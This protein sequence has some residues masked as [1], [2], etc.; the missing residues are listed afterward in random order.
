MNDLDYPFYRQ[1]GFF[2]PIGVM[3]AF[4]CSSFAGIVLGA[5]YGSLTPLVPYVYLNFTGTLGVGMGAGAAVYLGA[6]FGKIR[7][8]M[9]CGLI[10]S[11]AGVAALWG[12]WVAWIYALSSVDQAGVIIL[13]PAAI[14]NLMAVIGQEGV[15][16][17]GKSGSIPVRGATLYFVWVIEAGMIITIATFA[18]YVMMRGKPFCERCSCWVKHK[19]KLSELRPPKDYEV[20]DRLIAGD[21]S[22]VLTLE[23]PLFKGTHIQIE[24]LTC[25]T[26]D[27][28]CL[29]NIALVVASR[30]ED[31]KHQTHTEQ[32]ISNLRLSAADYQAIREFKGIAEDPLV[33][34]AQQ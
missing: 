19:I 10:G 34:T 14:W 2:G 25:R 31:G 20:F 22:G 4:A 8:T 17:F 6:V 15:W 27:E 24:L 16:G 1:S 21:I 29:I 3:T 12:A 26:C 28:M 11:V 18:A 32:L 13:S 7:N 5:I 30:D 9:F 23:R 33:V